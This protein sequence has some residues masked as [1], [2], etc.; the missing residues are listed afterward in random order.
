M[1]IGAIDSVTNNQLITE[2]S[3][4][5]KDDFFKLM[6]A[7]MQNQDPLNP[8][9]NEQFLAQLAQFSSLEQMQNLNQNFSSLAD[10]SRLG[11]TIGLIGKEV[12]Y[13]NQE[14]AEDSKGIVQQITLAEDQTMLLING[15]EVPLS[16]V[17]AIRPANGE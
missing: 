13:F 7:Q 11:N 17:L 4:L 3:S 12:L 5:G 9:D 15:S 6:I 14:T 16:Q 1:E 8:V 10:S 2:E